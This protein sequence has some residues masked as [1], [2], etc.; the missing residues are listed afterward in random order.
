MAFQPSQPHRRPD[1]VSQNQS[2]KDTIAS[3]ANDTVKAIK[4][5]LKSAG[6]YSIIVDATTDI[7]HMGQFSLSLRYVEK[8][9]KEIK[10]SHSVLPKQQTMSCFNI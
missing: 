4:T 3:L 2:Q 9:G 5:R 7:S 1:Y 8:T 6:F 10:Q